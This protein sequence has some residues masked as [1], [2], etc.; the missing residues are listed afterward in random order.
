MGSAH[1]QYR[2]KVAASGLRADLK[3]KVL[4]VLD[5]QAFTLEDAD[6]VRSLI[7][8]DIDADISAVEGLDEAITQDSQYQSVVAQMDEA[9]ASIDATADKALAGIVQAEGEMREEGR[10]Q[11][12][13]EVEARLG[14]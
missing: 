13:R 10:Q 2:Q 8:Q 5:K 3:E 9:L 11:G 12:L 6:L 7:Q 1:A 14:L 4:R